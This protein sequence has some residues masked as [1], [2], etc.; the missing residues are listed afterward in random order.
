MNRLWGSLSRRIR[1]GL[2]SFVI[3]A[4][5][6]SAYAAAN[7]TKLAHLLATRDP[8]AR[9]AGDTQIATGKGEKLYGVP[10]RENFAVA[11]GAAETIHGGA[12]G[13]ELGALGKK[14]K[15][16][17]P[18][19]GHAMIEGGP[20][21]TII[22]GGAGK[23]LVIEH[24]A[25]A[26]IDVRSPHDDVVA[27]GRHDRVI[28]S[29]DVRDE[30]IAIGKT[31]TV[32]ASCRHHGDTIE[33]A[34]VARGA[35]VQRAA[36]AHA[37]A[38]TGSGTND[39]PYVATGCSRL[40]AGGICQ[41]VFPSKTLTGFWANEYVPAYKCNNTYP[42]LY[43]HAYGVR[44][45]P[46][47]VAIGETVGSDVGV[48]INGISTTGPDLYAAGTLTGFPHSSATNW[49]FDPST[50]WVELFCTASAAQGYTVGGGSGNG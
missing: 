47:G 40:D 24:R 19:A 34:S 7:P 39:N 30:T 26:T 2:S 15:I 12:R 17:A 6:T 25:G 23:D 20:D 33:S 22:V 29:G 3:V 37:A 4:L 18:R 14:A 36:T 11:L 41:F 13:D 32:T 42:Y 10:D 45:V 16:I 1:L 9:I 49:S 27:A 43:G 44:P 50:Y 46:H 8:G 21:G 31:D 28:C 48:T 5:A 35:S 38:V